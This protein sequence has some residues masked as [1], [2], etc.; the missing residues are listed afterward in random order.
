MLS[1]STKP[2]VPQ[3]K[4]ADVPIVELVA[5]YKTRP[6]APNPVVPV[7]PLAAGRVP[8]TPLVKFT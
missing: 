7:P 3:V 2:E 1:L 4:L 6:V 5:A 8:V